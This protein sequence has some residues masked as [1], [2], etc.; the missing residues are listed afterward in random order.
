MVHALSTIEP[1][2]QTNVFLTAP[3]R[4]LQSEEKINMKVNSY[5]IFKKEGFANEFC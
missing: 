5:Q 4:V 3:F 2:L 1:K